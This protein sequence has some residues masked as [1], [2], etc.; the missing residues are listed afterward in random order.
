MVEQEKNFLGRGWSFPI[1]FNSSSRSVNMSEEEQDIR[2]SLRIIL[3]TQVG[4]RVMRP[5]FGSLIQESVFSS[6]DSVS[7]NRIE[8]QVKQALLE[9]EPRINVND[10]M[11]DTEN[12]YDGRLDIQIEYTIRLINV[13]T[14]IVFPYY[15]KEG[16]NLDDSLT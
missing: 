9:W 1:R 15:F 2:E 3:L 8:D 16:T 6:M 10:V 13:R 12:V 4:E 5:S 7:V 11:V 14:N